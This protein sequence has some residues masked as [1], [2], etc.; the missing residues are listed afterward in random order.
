MTKDV[1]G[2]TQERV[3]FLFGIHGCPHNCYGKK[4]FQ[5]SDSF[6]KYSMEE[7][8]KNTLS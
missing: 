6:F 5:V 7:G 1:L 4:C 8:K 2:R 3:R